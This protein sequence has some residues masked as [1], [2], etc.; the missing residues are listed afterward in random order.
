[1]SSTFDAMDAH[2]G[3]RTR[4]PRTQA[5]AKFQIF[6]VSNYG[7]EIQDEAY[8]SLESPIH[9]WNSLKHRIQRIIVLPLQACT[10][11]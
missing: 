9:R 3:A 6:W 10:P 7:L 11:S 8:V 5:Y 4:G 2:L 1:M